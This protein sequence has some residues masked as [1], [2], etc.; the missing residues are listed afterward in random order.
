MNPF[1]RTIIILADGARPDV[2]EELK[3][4]GELPNINKFIIEPGTYMRA[5][6]AFP[7]TT[8]PAYMPFLTGSL[9]ATCNVPGIR[10]FDKKKFA[11]KRFGKDR[12]R[13]YV[14]LETFYINRDMRRDIKTTFELMDDS[15]CIFNSISRGSGAGNLTR[16]MRIWY[17]YYA[18][19]T[20]HWSFVDGAATSKMIRALKKDP[21]FLFVVFPG[22]DEYSH[23]A[24]PKHPSAI[25]G[26]RRIDTAVG[27]LADEL[28]KKG[29]LEDTL[30]WIVSDHGLSE[31]NEHFCINTFLEDRG[32]RTFFYPLTFKKG[33]VVANMMSGNG[34]THLYFKNKDG[35]A[36]PTT[37]EE[38]SQ[39]HGDLISD[40]LRNDAVAVVAGRNSR[41]D[42]AVFSKDGM[43]NI[44]LEGGHIRYEVTGNDPFG[45]KVSSSSELV[46]ADD[47]LAETINSDYP[48]APYQLAHIFTSP[49]SGDLIVSARPGFDLRLKYEIPEHKGSHGSLH[50][51][52]MLVPLMCNAKL[53]ATC[54]RTVDIFPTYLKLLGLDVPARI[55]G[56]AL[57]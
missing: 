8:G 27:L 14:G 42:I 6:T 17:W 50:A 51:L 21:K 36:R 11:S 40:L 34:M 37:V 31:T 5:V 15:Y 45:Y 43:A 4:K 2:L 38:L 28:K 24:D 7:S 29:W 41:G 53:S 18:H 48:D 33:C 1:K 23:I 13:S 46:H 32:L 3:A 12:Y 30:I 22:I 44:L 9:P 20:D 26:Y 57:V 16:V 52:H 49:R 39:M 47:Y 35:W 54:A 10:W 56:K 25:D 19:L 55:D